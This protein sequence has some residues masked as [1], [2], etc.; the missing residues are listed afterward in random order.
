MPVDDKLVQ[1]VYFAD[2]QNLF[3]VKTKQLNQ[4]VLYCFGCETKTKGGTYCG[5]FLR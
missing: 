3:T 1:N 4:G 5:H 2:K